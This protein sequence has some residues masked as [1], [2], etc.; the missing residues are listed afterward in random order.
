[1]SVYAIGT[2]Y[3][4]VYDVY[5]MYGVVTLYACQCMPYARCMRVSGWVSHVINA[6]VCLLHVYDGHAASMHVCLYNLK[7]FS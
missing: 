4:H 7:R 3:V 1:M 5:I 2:L 6:S